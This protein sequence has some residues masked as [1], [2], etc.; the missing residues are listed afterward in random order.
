[1]RGV[2]TRARKTFSLRQKRKNCIDHD[3]FQ[4]SFKERVPGQAQGVRKWIRK[5]KRLY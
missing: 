3:S 2:W 1:M 4:E 5:G